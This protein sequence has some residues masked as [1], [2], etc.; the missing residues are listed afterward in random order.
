MPSILR[1]ARLQHR[2]EE[3][4]ANSSADEPTR[5]REF[6]AKLPGEPHSTSP[7]RAPLADASVSAYGFST[8]TRSV[9]LHG[10]TAAAVPFWGRTET[11]PAA[12]TEAVRVMPCRSRLND[13]RTKSRRR[14]RRMERCCLLLGLDVAEQGAQSALNPS[15]APHSRTACGKIL[16]RKW[17]SCAISS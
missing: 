17:P 2:H 15:I 8:R 6:I 14:H 5:Q 1:R 4:P 7:C 3:P 12:E 16:K 13:A 10:F 11:I 9:L